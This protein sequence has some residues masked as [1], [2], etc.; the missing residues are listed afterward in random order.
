ML[1]R[2]IPPSLGFCLHFR[3]N[4]LFLFLRSGYEYLCHHL[5]SL[6]ETESSVQ[7]SSFVM[8]REPSLPGLPPYFWSPRRGRGCRIFKDS[9]L[10]LAAHKDDCPKNKDSFHTTHSA[11]TKV[12]L[13][14]SDECCDAEKRFTWKWPT[15]MQSQLNYVQVPKQLNSRKL[16]IAQWEQRPDLWLPVQWPANPVLSPHAFLGAPVSLEL[17]YCPA[18]E[19]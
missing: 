9:L 13:E 5:Q 15:K 11:F 14:F 12:S 3:M 2:K 19:F 1:F 18:A 4:G 7:K 17:N 6:L 8:W 10:P 16:I